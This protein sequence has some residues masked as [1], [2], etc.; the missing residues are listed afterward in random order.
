MLNAASLGNQGGQLVS[1]DR[2]DL[3][4]AN[5]DLDNS[6]KGTLAS[7]K[8]LVIKLLAGDVQNQQDGLMFSQK[9]KLDLTARALTNDQGTLQS[10]TDNRLRLSGALSNQGGRVDS[11]SGNLTWKPPV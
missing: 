4:L 10:Q 1:Q 2:L 9:G 6:A 11:P 5:G 8:D 7:Q 3:T